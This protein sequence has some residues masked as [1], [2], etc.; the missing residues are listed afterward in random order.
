MLPRYEDVKEA[1]LNVLYL[2]GVR[3][4]G[5][6]FDRFSYIEK[7]EYWALIWGSAVM[8]TTGLM[9]W[10]ENLTLRFFPLWAVDLLTLIHYYEAWLATLAI[11]IWHFYFVIFNPDVYP[12]NWSWITGKISEDM[13]RR[14]HPCEYE[15]L[16]ES[17]QLDTPPSGAPSPAGPEGPAPSSGT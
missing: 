6:R 17:G 15:R 16:L 10:F 14:E 13:L 8:I 5:P 1:V 9:L 3:A 7:V 2:A 4:E 12:M 11:L